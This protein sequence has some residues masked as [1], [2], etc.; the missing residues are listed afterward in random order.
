MIVRLR[1]YDYCYL[2]LGAIYAKSLW[3]LTVVINF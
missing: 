1:M 2:N 3:Y